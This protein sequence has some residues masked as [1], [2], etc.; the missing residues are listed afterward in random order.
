MAGSVLATFH[1]PFWGALPT[2]GEL[3]LGERFGWGRAAVVQL[4]AIGLLAATIRRVERRRGSIA[5][6]QPARGGR[7]RSARGPWPLATGAVALAG[8]NAVTLV[9]AGHPWTITWAF[10]LWGGKALRA[11]GYDLSTVPFWTG[12]FQQTA[13]AAPIFADV[14]SVMD[15]GLVVGAFLGAGLAGRFALSRRI[16]PSVAAASLLGGLLLGYGS[17]IA[18]GCNIGAYVSGIASTSL[19]GWVWAAGAIVGTPAGVYLRRRMGLAGRAAA[20]VC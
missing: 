11:T 5:A 6:P 4:A 8:L 13:L 15:I 17:R 20:A 18:F 9:L 7:A 10:T 14:T 2:L 12:E 16:A 3:V 1:M 19:H